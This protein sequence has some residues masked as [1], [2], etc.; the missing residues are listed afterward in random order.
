V[1]SAL[2]AAKI[3]DKIYCNPRG[4]G[5]KGLTITMGFVRKPDKLEI[6]PE[7][8]YAGKFKAPLNPCCK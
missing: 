7:I 8:F 2:I 6:Q 5:L 1:I 4:C 3:A